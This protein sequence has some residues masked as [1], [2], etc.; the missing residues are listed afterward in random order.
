LNSGGEKVS[1]QKGTGKRGSWA[2][3]TGRSTKTRENVLD[4]CGGKKGNRKGGE[5]KA[6][7]MGKT[8]VRRVAKNNDSWKTR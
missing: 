1:G 2:F 4:T 8:G 6:T 7:A 3:P 5:L